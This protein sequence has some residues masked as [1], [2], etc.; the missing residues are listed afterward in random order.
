MCIRDR[1]TVT[2]RVLE[3]GK[4]ISFV[5]PADSYKGGIDNTSL[6][7]ATAAGLLARDGSSFQP[8]PAGAA[9]AA[10]V[11]GTAVVPRPG[12]APAPAA[13][14]QELL[15]QGGKVGV[16]VAWKNQYDGSSGNATAIPKQEAYGYFYFSTPTNA[17]VFVKVLDFGAASPYLLFWA[18]LTDFQYTLTFRNTATGKSWSY[19]KAPGSYDGGA[20]TTDLPH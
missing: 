10:G 19:T 20:N 16:K 4:S 18:G 8:L 7:H 11:V 2:F 5:T 17:E 3:S 13:D 15:L 14:A 6:P 9:G 1:Y 12:A